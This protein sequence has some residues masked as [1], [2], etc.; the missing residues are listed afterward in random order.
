MKSKSLILMFVSLGFGLIAAIGISQVM[1]RSG[2]SKNEVKMG[3]VLVAVD[4]I[5]T[6]RELTEEVVRVEEWPANII[7]EN[8][9]RDLSQIQNMSTVRAIPRGAPIFATD[10]IDK[11][12]QSNIN[13]KD[14][15]RVVFIKV[16]AESTGHGLLKPGDRVDIIGSF[17]QGF[18][19]NQTTVA[20][21]F[22]KNIEVYS[23]NETTE[24]K[25]PREATGAKQNSIVGVILNQKQAEKVALVQKV[26]SLTFTIRGM[27]SFSG[28]EE[29]E[30]PL[31]SWLDPV[32]TASEVNVEPKETNDKNNFS[33][34]MAA[35]LDSMKASSNQKPRETMR[36]YHGQEVQV[37]YINPDGSLTETD[38]ENATKSQKNG[39][40]AI[41]FDSPIGKPTR[42]NSGLE[43]TEVDE[44][45]NEG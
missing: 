24:R 36:V 35:F 23:V 20:S 45:I 40:P 12:Q 34:Q 39:M 31:P 25:G 22:L 17:S 43:E 29:V 19:Q 10:I 5:E 38:S 4:F 28:R 21:T 18:G 16:G 8:V 27:E 6:S 1:G 42:Q 3:Q 44:Y 9:I 30:D 32:K 41:D 33:A 11:N 14:G 13:L 15:Q 26:G 2:G 37:F 7:P